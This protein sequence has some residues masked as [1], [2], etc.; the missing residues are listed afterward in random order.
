MTSNGGR[1]PLRSF[2]TLHTIPQPPASLSPTA[3]DETSGDTNKLLSDL[4]ASPLCDQPISHPIAA[5]LRLTKSRL[6]SVDDERPNS[7]QAAWAW[8]AN[9][10]WVTADGSFLDPAGRRLTNTAGDPPD[11][12]AMIPFPADAR[13]RQSEAAVKLR[14]R[15][16]DPVADLLPLRGAE[17]INSMAADAVAARALALFLSATRAESILAGQPLDV[18]NMRRRCPLGFAALSPREQAFFNASVPP[19]DA[20][21]TLVW[22]YES[23]FA[24][25]WALGMQ[26]ELPW[27]DEHADLTAVT[28]LMIDLPDAAIVEQAR[29]RPMDELLDAAELHHQAFHAVAEAEQSGRDLSGVLDMGVLCERLIALSWVCGLSPAAPDWDATTR[30]VESGCDPFA[31]ETRSSKLP[32]SQ[33]RV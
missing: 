12:K 11:P 30:W 6:C 8:Q 33:L 23:L 9:A 27:P 32:A 3:S 29:L 31:S 28:R 13:R 22:R 19:I 15:M 17:E 18:V 20:S 10:I 16:I 1:I 24:I 26:F 4:V 2:S 25:Q 7:E 5:H 14:N 21:N